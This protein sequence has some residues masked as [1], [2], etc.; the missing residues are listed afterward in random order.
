[1]SWIRH[2]GKL[3]HN[4]IIFER[5]NRDPCQY[6]LISRFRPFLLSIAQVLFFRIGC[7]SVS[8]PVTR[9]QES[10]NLN[11]YYKTFITPCTVLEDM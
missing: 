7:E 4:S 10:N 2:L 9:K 11:L 1:M 5:F 8:E 3:L 6:N